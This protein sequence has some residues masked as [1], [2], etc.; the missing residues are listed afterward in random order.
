MLQPE[1]YSRIRRDCKGGT[2]MQYLVIMGV[3]IAVALILIVVI[4]V[5]LLKGKQEEQEDYDES[6]E[7]GE[8]I[9]A[10]KEIEAEEAP[11]RKRRPAVQQMGNTA[12]EGPSVIG[13]GTNHQ[14]EEGQ[15]EGQEADRV[16]G[17][18]L[19]KVVLENLGNWQKSTFVFYENIGIGRGKSFPQFEK[20]LT[21]SDDPRV[22]KMHCAIIEKD[23]K[24]YLKD[25]GSRNGTYL[26]GK[27]ITQPVLLQRDDTIRVGETE[28]EIQSMMREK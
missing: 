13:Q 26:N 11:R 5:A 7:Y 12:D 19:W 2:H 10:E 27:R 14:N 3:L 1:K 20:F 6:E 18:K 24:L 4:I 22:S 25:M 17:K 28:I 21:V 16:P 8:G 23:K 9:E 15:K